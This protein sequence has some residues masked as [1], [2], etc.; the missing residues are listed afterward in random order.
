MGRTIDLEAQGR[1]AATVRRKFESGELK[2]RGC[3]HSPSWR[4]KMASIMREKK[5]IMEVQCNFNES[6]CRFIDRLNAQK[7]WN[8]QHA[9]NG[10]EI[11]IGPYSLDG[12]DRD[13]NI[14]FEYDEDCTRHN[15]K[16]GKLKD[17][18]RQ[19]FIIEK[20]GCEFWRYSE[21]D[22]LLYRVDPE[23]NMRIIEK[24]FEEKR[25]SR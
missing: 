19:A 4:A 21:R 6:A 18:C 1:S 5:G 14:A 15:S 25:A 8:L 2:H 12:Y 16:N 17:R 3:P 10:G 11:R 22:D 20:T 23:E 13:R 7:G 9:L 24:E